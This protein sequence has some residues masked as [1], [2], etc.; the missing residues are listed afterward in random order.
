MFLLEG[1]FLL[2][3]LLLLEC[4]ASRSVELK[5]YISGVYRTRDH[6]KCDIGSALLP[7][8]ASHW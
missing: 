6:V 2:A 1:L 7:I 4:K 5:N 3:G 8:L